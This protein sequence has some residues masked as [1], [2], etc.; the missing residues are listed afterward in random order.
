MQWRTNPL[1]GNRSPASQPGPG[2]ATAPAVTSR[3]A[4]LE[5]ALGRAAGAPERT[6][7]LAAGFAPD[8]QQQQAGQ[9][10]PAPL[11]PAQRAQAP[12]L[13]ASLDVASSEG[14]AP[15]L[16]NHW[17]LPDAGPSGSDWLS[18]LCEPDIE[19]LEITSSAKPRQPPQQPSQHPGHQQQLQEEEEDGKWQ[20][21]RPGQPRM[22]GEG[23][24]PV[25]GTQP[26]LQDR[27]QEP[28]QLRWEG[29]GQLEA[30]DEE[31]WA[32]GGGGGSSS[33]NSSGEWPARWQSA[34]KT[35]RSEAAPLLQPALPPAP[36]PTGP[37]GALPT[38]PGLS[39]L[40][41]SASKIAGA[42]VPAAAAQQ[43]EQ[44]RPWDA[45]FPQQGTLFDLANMALDI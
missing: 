19:Q 14:C 7:S 45:G 18:S 4:S 24:G 29:L 1:A 20:Q 41:G 30:E 31:G 6:D 9:A 5:D 44:Q 28:R 10:P 35:A 27:G 36:A 33:S 39:L 16:S 43:Q 11:P 15:S 32:P 21:P 8:W 37:A 17:T 12:A 22:G 23:H 34:A 13:R 25:D 26:Q 2:S 40:D 38:L 3:T 42:G